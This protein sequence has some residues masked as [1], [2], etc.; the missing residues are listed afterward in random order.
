MKLRFPLYYRK[1]ACIADKCSDNCCIGWE[2]DVDS[3]T[4]AFY[5]SVDG[6]M[7]EKLR[8]NIK[9]GSF[10]LRGE[11]CPFLNDRNLCQII[12][13]LGEEHLCHICR[14]HP[15]FYGWYGDIK[16][17]GIGLGCEEA[18]RLILTEGTGEWFET[19]IPEEDTDIPDLSTHSFLED[20][21]SAIFSYMERRDIPFA[22]KSATIIDY[23]E[24][25]Q[26]CLDFGIFELPPMEPSEPCGTADFSTFTELFSRF[27]PIDESWTDALYRLKNKKPVANDGFLSNIFVYFIWRYFMRAVFDGDVISKIKL[28]AVSCAMISLMA[29]GHD[30]ES[31]ISAAKLYSKEIE[32]SEEN[33]E[34]LCRMTLTEQAFEN[35]ALKGIIP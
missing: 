1:F 4:E 11:R 8:S 30:L 34:L 29:L 31:Y 5:A 32:Y 23:G 7:G 3:S 20:A 21:R 12:I 9:N 22:E 28:A 33:L 17:G 15:R 24:E 2:I 18:A 13:N 19:D 25:L 6:E 27:E 10:I 26:D 14:Q 35:D 16:E